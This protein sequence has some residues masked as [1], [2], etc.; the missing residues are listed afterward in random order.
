MSSFVLYTNY[1]NQF[2]QE[3]KRI[4]KGID[5]GD[6]NYEKCLVNKSLLL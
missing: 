2:T 1:R 3:T 4:A 5:K 6:K